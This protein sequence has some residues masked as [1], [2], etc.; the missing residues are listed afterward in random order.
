MAP[1][2]QANY[3]RHE[4]KGVVS[5]MSETEKPQRRR[6]EHRSTAANRQRI[7]D[8][9]LEVAHEFGYQGTTIPR[10]SRKANLPT[11]SVYW[12]FDSKDALFA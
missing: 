8:A 2:P 4:S 9:T 7:L 3:F 11:G 5:R 12:H 6:E 1:H 10:V